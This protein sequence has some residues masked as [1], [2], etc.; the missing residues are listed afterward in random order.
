MPE[1]ND[2]ERGRL[3]AYAR[4]TEPSPADIERALT[5][6]L[7]RVPHSQRAPNLPD[8]RRRVVWM[9]AAGFAT[10]V[11]ATAAVAGV[12]WL[13]ARPQPELPELRSE[14]AS[15]RYGEARLE[16]ADTAG[17]DSA[18]AL[19]P[20]EPEPDPDPRDAPAQVEAAEVAPDPSPA[21]QPRARHR[22]PPRPASEPAAAKDPADASS[23][24]A[25]ESR[26]LARVRRALNNQDFASAL[27]W[28]EEHARRHPQGALTEER[29]ILE[30]VAAC[31]GDQRDR[32]LESLATLREQFPKAAAIAKVEQSCPT[33]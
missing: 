5:R 28:A 19:A 9:A 11:I 2:E 21:P 4:A 32:G 20:P 17:Q 27:D 15:P 10:L 18:P 16:Q 14:S 7:A 33:Q 25:E 8:G 24:L 23:R 31:R 1:L 13:R 30:A 12:R 3:D 29:L 6:T 26:L 22:Q